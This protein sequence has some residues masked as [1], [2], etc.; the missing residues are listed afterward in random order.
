[1]KVENNVY[2]KFL[3]NNLKDKIL[4]RHL[5]KSDGYVYYQFIRDNGSL[6]YFYVYRPHTK[7]KEKFS[8]ISLSSNYLH[9]K[10][11]QMVL[12]DET[13]KFCDGFDKEKTKYILKHGSFKLR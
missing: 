8:R 1:M 6:S 11:K 13:D 12:I 5:P 10:L 7:R 3:I 9:L 4:K 2:E